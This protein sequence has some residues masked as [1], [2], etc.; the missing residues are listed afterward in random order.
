MARE[1]DDSAQIELFVIRQNLRPFGIAQKAGRFLVEVTQ[2]REVKPLDL[3]V[4]NGLLD[5]SQ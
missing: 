3:T 1:I 2:Q 4:S 5:S